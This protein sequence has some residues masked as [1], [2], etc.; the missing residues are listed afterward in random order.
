MGHPLCLLLALD[1]MYYEF[2]VV[3]PYYFDLDMD[4][5]LTLDPGPTENILSFFFSIIKNLILNYDFFVV[6]Y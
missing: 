5:T 2:S 1:A 4:P 6:I 3:N